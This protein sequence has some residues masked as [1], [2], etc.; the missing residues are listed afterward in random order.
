VE[1]GPK[2]EETT[3][4]VQVTLT[5]QQISALVKKGEN[6]APKLGGVAT[7]LLSD[8][9]KGGLMLEPGVA[10]QISKYLKNVNW[11]GADLLPIV[12]RGV[13]MQGDN[14]IA[15]WK[16]DPTYEPMFRELAEN[17]GRTVNELVQELMDWAAG[18][19]WFYQWEPEPK[20]L[21]FTPEDYKMLAEATGKE[22]PTGTDIAS[23]VREMS[24]SPVAAR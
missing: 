6:T 8:L 14:F 2:N 20:A 1:T 19:G 21:R 4:M 9:A 24:A 3:I 16:I 5:H 15:T 23:F 17:Q 18:Q 12:E 11:N 10:K 22:D 13:G 7:W